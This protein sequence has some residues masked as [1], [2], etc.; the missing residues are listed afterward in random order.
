[1]KKTIKLAVVAALALGT[2]S[3]FATNGSNLIATG[4]KARGMGGTAIGIANGAE[5]GLSNPA[6]ITKVKST[7]ISFGGTL[8][9]PD[10]ENENGLNL[11]GMGLADESGSANSEADMSVIPEVSIASKI[12]DNFYTGIGIWG[13]AGMG[14]DYRDSDN[15][16]QMEMVTNLQLMQF[17]VP[18]AF[19]TGAFSAAIT[20]VLQYG[21][22]DIGYTMSED[23]RRGMAMM[24]GAPDP[25]AGIGASTVG[26]GVA[27]DL[28][29]G[30]NIGLAYEIN[31]LTIGAIYKSQIDMEYTD[32]LSTAAGAMTNGAYTNDK[33]STPKE[34]GIGVSYKIDGHTIALDY[35]KIKWSSAEGYKDFAWDD[36]TVYAIGYEYAAKNWSLRAGYNHASSP[37]SEQDNAAGT[38]G[39]SGGIINTFNLL[40]FPGI[41]ETHYTI[42]GTYAFTDQFSVDLAYVYA[43]ENTQTYE[44]FVQQDITTKHSQDSF[45]VGLNYNF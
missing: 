7:E 33:L 14:V 45:S 21:S 41:V 43:K 12:T 24:A 13:T 25:G 8:F 42:G 30:Y 6:L 23:L 4:V 20:P 2:T 26:E 5:S 19:T 15:T 17:G 9:M 32:V 36:Q 40:G 1:M 18:L 38:N 28:K 22:L 27:Q 37:I 44:N 16:G 31:N 35:K 34:Y 39:L 3:A 11:G 10:V 29:F